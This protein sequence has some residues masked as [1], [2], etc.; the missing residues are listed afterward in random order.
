M[1]I[2][3]YREETTEK[4]MLNSRETTEWLDYRIL[5][6]GSKRYPVSTKTYQGKWKRVETRQ[7]FYTKRGGER[8]MRT[9]DFFFVAFLDTKLLRASNFFFSELA[10]NKSETY[11]L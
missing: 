4:F 5:P 9:F 8:R 1:Y 2:G 6:W 10:V 3:L 11:V 7:E